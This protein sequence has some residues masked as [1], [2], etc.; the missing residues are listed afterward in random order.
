MPTPTPTTKDGAPSSRRRRFRRRR[1]DRLVSVA[2][3]MAALAIVASTLHL[4]DL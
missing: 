4:P 1:Y 3:V 2:L